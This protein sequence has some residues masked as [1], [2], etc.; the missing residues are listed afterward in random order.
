MR[1]GILGLIV[2]IGTTASTAVVSGFKSPLTRTVIAA[3]ANRPVAAIF[4]S[5]MAAT[6]VDNN[7]D[8]PEADH[9]LYDV[10][11]SNNGARCRIVLYKK[12][13]SRDRVNIISPASIGG[14]KSAEY[15]RLSPLG[16]MPCLS[17]RKAAPYDGPSSL[18]ESDTIARYLLNEYSDVGPSFQPDNPRS[19]QICRWHDMYLTPIQGCMYKPSSRLPFGDYPD[20]K[21]A[22]SAY[23]TNLNIIEG[24]MAEE[25]GM[26]GTGSPSS[27]PSYLC[28][29]G[30]VSLADATLFP[31]CVFA[32]YMLP[33][34]DE[35]PTR[36]MPPL[37]PRLTGWFDDLR[38]NDE[39]FSRVYREIMDTL[40]TS[41]EGTNRRWDDIWLAGLRDTAPST[42]FD[43]IISGD[44]PADVV[45][46]DEHVLAFRDINPMAPVHVLIIPKDRAGLTSLRKATAEHTNILGR[47]LLAAGEIAN[48][49]TLG[50]GDGA[51]IVINDGPDGGQE[52][53]HLHVHVLGGRKMGRT[54][55]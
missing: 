6:S 12:N 18:A 16:L 30:E 35:D 27:S 53:N 54:F 5:A 9:V 36:P 15:K 21:S 55:G 42:I 37:P 49:E 47:M 31:S 17:I 2:A 14:L 34:F 25:D 41:W 8:A 23:R 51:R 11:V 40:V 46:E 26:T 29:G 4:P 38:S 24:F 13:I 48:D 28:G 32:S 7:N 22:I 39:A 33:K 19:N 1:A 10:P 44:I 3:T 52:V 43:E 45:R 50:F 20:R